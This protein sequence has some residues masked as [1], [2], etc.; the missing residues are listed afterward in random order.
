MGDENEMHI[1]I[2]QPGDNVWLGGEICFRS[3][4]VEPLVHLHSDPETVGP[5]NP[6]AVP[7]N[8]IQVNDGEW[9][10]ITATWGDAVGNTSMYL[11]SFLIMSGAYTSRQTSYTLTYMYLGH[12]AAGNRRYDAVLD[13][14]QIYN[15][16]LSLEEIYVLV[17]GDAHL[18]WLPNP[19]D[20]AIEVPIDAVDTRFLYRY[21]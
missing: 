17:V 19:E 8:P 13:E 1:Y 7:V 21:P 18:S 12:M 3:I 11:D 14:V 16:A 9:H 5:D 15:N 4:N 10:H 20:G 2:E 6:G